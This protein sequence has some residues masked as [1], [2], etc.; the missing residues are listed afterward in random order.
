MM[1]VSVDFSQSKVGTQAAISCFIL[2]IGQGSG[3][4]PLRFGWL[5]RISF[6]LLSG[7]S[8]S[9]VIVSLSSGPIGVSAAQESSRNDSFWSGGQA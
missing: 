6:T 8:H 5:A 9:S 4:L 2:L 1:S 3:F 7:C